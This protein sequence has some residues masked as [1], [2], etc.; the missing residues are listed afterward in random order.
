MHHVLSLLIYRCYDTKILYNTT[1]KNIY[2]AL[3]VVGAWKRISS[4]SPFCKIYTDCLYSI[5]SLLLLPLLLVFC[6]FFPD[7]FSDP[8]HVAYM[9]RVIWERCCYIFDEYINT[10]FSVFSIPLVKFLPTY[11]LR[12]QGTLL[13]AYTSTPKYVLYVNIFYY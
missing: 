12:M 11:I 8:W 10:S 13:I 1:Q 7:A 3:C 9:Y 2:Y 4:H 6:R 5:F